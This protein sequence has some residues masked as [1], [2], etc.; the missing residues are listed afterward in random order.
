[1]AHTIIE[2]EESPHLQLARWKLGRAN[3]VV[4]SEPKGLSTLRA[5]S[6][7]SIQKSSTLETH[8]VLIF[9]FTT[10]GKKRPMSQLSVVRPEF[11]ELMGG[12]IIL[13]LCRPSTD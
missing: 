13:V 6:I 8:K 1:M 11:L 12:S 9:P 2:A 5:D 3:G 7:N 10:T 4:Q